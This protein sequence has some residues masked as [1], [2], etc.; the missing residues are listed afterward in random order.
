MFQTT[1]QIIKQMDKHG[2]RFI[3]VFLHTV[4]LMPRAT[5][6]PQLT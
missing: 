6:T 1:N 4:D 5:A 2:G 3:S